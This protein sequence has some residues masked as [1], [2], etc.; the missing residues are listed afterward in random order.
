MNKVFD[1]FSRLWFEMKFQVKMNKDLEDQYFKFK[2]RAIRIDEILRIGMLS[3][4]EVDSD[5][6]FAAGLEDIFVETEI[7]QVEVQYIMLPI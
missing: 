2:P 4:S 5:G 1:H 7:T 6:S 3:L